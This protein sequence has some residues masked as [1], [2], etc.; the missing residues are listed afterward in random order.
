MQPRL[1]ASKVS[2]PYSQIYLNDLDMSADYM[3][4]MMGDMRQSL[5]QVF[6]HSE[7][8]EVDAELAK[9]GETSVRL[10]GT[11]KVSASEGY[12]RG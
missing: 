7:L 6:L 11:A 3:D 5:P 9:L 1:Q 4:R 12:R 2:S 10:R 8:A